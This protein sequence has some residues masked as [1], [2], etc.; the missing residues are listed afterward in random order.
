MIEKPRNLD[1][2]A[3]ARILPENNLKIILTDITDPNNLKELIIDSRD[4][5]L[6]LDFLSEPQKLIWNC[7][8]GTILWFNDNMKT[9]SWKDGNILCPM[10]LIE[11]QEPKSISEDFT[12]GFRLEH[13]ENIYKGDTNPIISFAFQEKNTIRHQRML[14]LAPEKPQQICESKT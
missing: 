14:F 1:V 10:E 12:S 7:V 11:N 6:D 8:E 4:K 5:V 2:L 13:R 3:T 9:G